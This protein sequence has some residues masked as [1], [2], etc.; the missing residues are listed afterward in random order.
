MTTEVD[1]R[2]SYYLKCLI[3]GTLASS[4]SHGLFTPL[5]LYKTMKQCD[6]TFT[7]S[8]REVMSKLKEHSGLRGVYTGFRPTIQAYGIHGMVKYTTYEVMKE[9]LVRFYGGDINKY[10]Y[11]ICFMSAGVAEFFSNLL[12]CPLEV[13]KIRLQSS[14]LQLYKNDLEYDKM[15]KE[16]LIKKTFKLENPLNLYKGL[17]LILFRQIPLTISVF[18]TFE[19]TSQILYDYIFKKSRSELTLGNHLFVSLIS[20]YMSGSL[21]C[22][23]VSHPADTLIT[24]I[25]KYDSPHFSG[26]ITANIKSIYNNIKLKGLFTGIYPRGFYIGFLIP[27]QLFLYDC[28]KV[29]FGLKTTASV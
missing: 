19:V 13:Y 27:T 5:D 24:N 14:T 16:A 8:L 25:Y 7:P 22:A 1:N 15:K 10:R 12:I 26:K 17:G 20:S 4:F 3:G 9:K 2:T 28:L 29:S 6:I 21:L 11:R 18:C 23:I